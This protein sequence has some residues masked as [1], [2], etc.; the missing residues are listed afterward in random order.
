MDR[1]WPD[2]KEEKT[3]PALDALLLYTFPTQGIVSSY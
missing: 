3:P 2:V 1:D